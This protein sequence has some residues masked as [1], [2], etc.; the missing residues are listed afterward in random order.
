M[1]L[2]G[3]PRASFLSSYYPSHRHLIIQFH[4]VYWTVGAREDGLR[5]WLCSRAGCLAS[6][7]FLLCCDLVT[8]AWGHR[9]KVSR[10]ISD[11]GIAQAN[12]TIHKGRSQQG[13]AAASGITSS[14]RFSCSLSFFLLPHCLLL[15]PCFLSSRSVEPSSSQLVVVTDHFSRSRLIC[16][17]SH[18]SILS[19]PL[20]QTSKLPPWSTSFRLSSSRS[21]P[22]PLPSA[23]LPCPPAPTS[24]R[25]R[26][27]LLVE[28]LLSS[29][30]AV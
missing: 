8:G 11:G 10:Y 22:P 27:S 9:S 13:T 16:Q 12:S 28:L 19:N 17:P 2:A 29:R 24:L 3:V 30:R 23:P 21:P 7:S 5:V 26:R 14:F 20:K 25:L 4:L 18:R 1:R 15:I 6:G